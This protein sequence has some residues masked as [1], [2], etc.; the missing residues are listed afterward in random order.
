MITIGR[1]DEA[2]RRLFA[3][4]GMMADGAI[5]SSLIQYERG[6]NGGGEVTA[7]VMYHDCIGHDTRISIGVKD[8]RSLSRRF[9]WAMS[10]YAFV[11]MGVDRVSVNI[12]QSNRRS[13]KFAVHYGF[14]LE[15][16]KRRGYANGENMIMMGILKEECRWLALA[17]RYGE[18]QDDQ[19]Q[20][21]GNTQPI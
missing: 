15:G 19:V 8:G 7:A 16:T 21:Q 6:P 11:R 17:K 5:Y 1:H 18:T 9:V 4:L 20:H 10:D 12:E 13:L 3:E 14:V 2:A